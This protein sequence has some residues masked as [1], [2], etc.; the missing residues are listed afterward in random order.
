MVLIQFKMPALF[1]EDVEK[2]ILKFYGKAKRIGQLIFS[3]KKT[4]EGG[5]SLPISRLIV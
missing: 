4:T 5:I 1:F 3:E 2:I